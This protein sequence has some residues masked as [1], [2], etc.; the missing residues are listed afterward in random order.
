M[1]NHGTLRV[2]CSKIVLQEGQE[3]VLSLSIGQASV[4]LRAREEVEVDGQEEYVCLQ[5]LNK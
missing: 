1:I 4:L 5:L 3:G 2:A